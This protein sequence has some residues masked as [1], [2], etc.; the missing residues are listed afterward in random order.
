MT[1]VRQSG[2]VFDSGEIIREKIWTYIS[3]H[4]ELIHA[5]LQW[6]DNKRVSEG[7]YFCPEGGGYLVAY[8]PRGT[9]FTFDND[10]EACAEFV[11]REIESLAKFA[12]S[13]SN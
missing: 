7:W 9:R 3:E 2:Y 13:H 11:F 1:L 6:S 4:K 5:W 12:K 10:V 8:H